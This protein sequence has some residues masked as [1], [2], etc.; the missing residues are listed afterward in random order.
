MNQL[1]KTF[2]TAAL[3]VAAFAFVIVGGGTLI[4]FVLHH[5]GI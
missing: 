5:L 1:G 4:A 2:V 3:A